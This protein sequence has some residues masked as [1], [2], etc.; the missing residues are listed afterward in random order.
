MS[1]RFP[2]SNEPALMYEDWVLLQRALEGSRREANHRASL[3][4]QAKIQ[5]IP[6]TGLLQDVRDRLAQLNIEPLGTFITQP[7]FWF[8]KNE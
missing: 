1:K 6:S 7:A 2:G 8:G 4:R 5:A 3:A